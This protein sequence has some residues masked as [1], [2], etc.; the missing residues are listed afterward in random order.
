M[1]YLQ[2]RRTIKILP[3]IHLHLSKSGVSASIG[4]RGASLNIGPRG[5]YLTLG[6]PGSGVSYRTKLSEEHNAQARRQSP[7]LAWGILGVLLVLLIALFLVFVFF[8]Q[9]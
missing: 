8:G 3:G 9:D 1:G 7:E 6:L 4:R 5:R 2:F